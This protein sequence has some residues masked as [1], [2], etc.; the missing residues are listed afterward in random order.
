MA[1]RQHYRVSQHFDGSHKSWATRATRATSDIVI[2]GR[3][4]HRHYHHSSMYVISNVLYPVKTPFSMHPPAPRECER[5]SFC[6]S[7]P[8]IT[9][10]MSFVAIDEPRLKHVRKPQYLCVCASS[11]RC[12]PRALSLQT[13]LVGHRN[14]HSSRCCEIDSFQVQEYLS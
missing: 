14:Q 8:S 6:L 12:R 4:H 3:C 5:C 13:L 9:P 10:H 2:I 1:S 11:G 7:A